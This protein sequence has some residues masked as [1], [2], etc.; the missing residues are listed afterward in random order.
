MEIARSY[1]N[2]SQFHYGS[3]KTEFL[4]ENGIKVERSQFHYG[5]IKTFEFIEG[6]FTFNESQFHYGSIKTCTKKNKYYWYRIVSIP[7]WFD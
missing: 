1:G 4:K 2:S 5:S 6:S 3:I 7:L